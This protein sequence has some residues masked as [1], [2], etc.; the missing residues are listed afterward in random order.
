MAK[1]QKPH[2]AEDH[3]PASTENSAGAEERRPADSRATQNPI[4]SIDALRMWMTTVTKTRLL[5]REEEVEV[6][7]RIRAGDATA[8]EQLIR[9]N[10]RLVIS[11]AAKY[12][13]YNVP[14]ADLIQE[15][16]IGLLRAVEKFDHTRGFKFST[17]AIWWIRQA[18]L[19]ALDNYSRV[20]RLP[21]YVVAKVSRMERTITRLGQ[22]LEREPTVEEIGAE[23]EITPDEVRELMAIPSELLS[24]E[25]PIDDSPT[26]PAL[27]DFIQ[28]LDDWSRDPL[29]GIIQT[30]QVR[31]MLG[32]LPDK[33]R[34]MMLL[35]FGLEGNEEHTLREIGVQFDVTRERVRQIELD[36]MR[37][38][39]QVAAAEEYRESQRG[40]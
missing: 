6:A 16:N 9:C 23:L 8:R 32:A 14:L 22:D 38:L 31:R 4:S 17:Y 13:G 25:L 11:V 33:E 24:L 15:G 39:R 40:T 3:T 10:L 37:R 26:S 12:A 28:D 5:T 18:V 1:T 36:V 34:R 29:D 19:R 2:L 35:R 27:R 7:K 20:I 21:T 30:E